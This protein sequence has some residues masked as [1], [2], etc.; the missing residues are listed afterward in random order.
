MGDTRAATAFFRGRKFRRWNRRHIVP[1]ARREDATVYPFYS[2]GRRTEKSDKEK[3]R[4]M[5][6]KLNEEKQL[7]M[8]LKN[9]RFVPELDRL[10][11]GFGTSVNVC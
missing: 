10:P 6:A 9:K 2:I 11:I 8:D 1:R 4:E 7:P 5:V 3:E